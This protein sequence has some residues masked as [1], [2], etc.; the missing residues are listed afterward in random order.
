MHRVH[1]ST[2][3]HNRN[4]GFNLSIWDQ[5]FGTCQAAPTVPTIGLQ[6]HRAPS[7]SL[8]LL[9]QPFVKYNTPP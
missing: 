5:L 2:R 9:A 1:H 6:T 4:F 3:D 7:N 8:Q